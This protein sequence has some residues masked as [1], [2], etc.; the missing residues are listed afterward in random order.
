M[1]N[2]AC[3]EGRFTASPDIKE[4]NGKKLANFQIAV[5]RSYKQNGVYGVD[6]L[7]CVAWGKQADIVERYGQKGA[8]FGFEAQIKTDVYK[9][10]DGPSRKSVAFVVHGLHFLPNGRNAETEVQ[11]EDLMNEEDDLPL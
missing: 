6:Y 1:L 10:A 2:I 11:T 4:V 5:P 3:F 9:T 8:L 7:D